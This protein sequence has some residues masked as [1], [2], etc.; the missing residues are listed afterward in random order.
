MNIAQL[1]EIK[2]EFH[3]SMIIAHIGRAYV[4]E[5]VGN[6]LEIYAAECPDLMFDFSANCCEYAIHELL[7]LMGPKN[8]LFGSDLPILRMR[9]G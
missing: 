3:K 4:K 6:A 8:A 7:R 5:N 1:L 9:A 2:R